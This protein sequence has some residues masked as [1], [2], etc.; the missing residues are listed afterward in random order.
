M[1][2]KN[3]EIDGK[4]ETANIYA[5]MWEYASQW[6]ITHYEL[7]PSPDEGERIIGTW[8]PIDDVLCGIMNRGDSIESDGKAY[9]WLNAGEN[10]ISLV[11]ADEV[12]YEFYLIY[13]RTETGYQATGQIF[14]SRGE[15]MVNV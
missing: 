2:T 3:I 8:K 5:S 1:R 9:L 14:E 6:D 4:T 7:D 15:A 11:P 10:E 12:E 13:A